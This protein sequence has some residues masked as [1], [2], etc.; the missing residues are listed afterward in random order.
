MRRLFLFRHAK[1]EP[2]DARPDH[3]RVL[4]KRGRRDAA[5][6]G[7]R[8]AER[9]EIPGLVICST[10]R[11]TLETWQLAGAAFDPPPPMLEDARIYEAPAERLLEVVRGVQPDSEGVMLVGHNPGFE[12]LVGLLADRAGARR[13]SKAGGTMPTA[14]IAVLEADAAGWRDLGP[15][16]MRLVDFL[17]PKDED[18]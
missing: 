2:H 6:M 17:S 3:E 10:S 14:A 13:W 12:D 15:G 16:S 4:D 9:G 5:A 7:E 1:A 18:G 11:R 8:L